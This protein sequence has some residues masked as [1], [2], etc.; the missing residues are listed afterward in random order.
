MAETE[1]NNNGNTKYALFLGCTIPYRLPF[2]EAATRFVFKKLGL[3]LIDLPFG[4]CPDPNGIRSYDEKTWYALAARNLSLAEEQNL[5][6]I[7]LCNGCFETLAYVNK[8]LQDDKSLLGEVNKYLAKIN[9]KYEAKISVIHFHQ[10]LHDVIGYDTLKHFIINPLKELN[11]A[12]HYGCHLLRPKKV[13]NVEEPENP[14]WLWE[15]V[16][17][18]LQANPTHYLDETLCCGAGIR[19]VEQTTSLKIT[20]HKIKNMEMAEANA[21]LV[22]C[23][24]CHLQFDAGQKLILKAEENEYPK[25]NGIPV[26]YQAEL[27][28]IA[29][30]ADPKKLGIQYHMVKPKIEMLKQKTTAV[31]SEKTVIATH[32]HS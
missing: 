21:I 27:L 13:L 10:F 28:A 16:E 22:P 14:E 31:T 5:N 29:M 26:F 19:E 6:I 24:T 3:E 25:I 9:R 11:I 2:L 4:C 23:P 30:G 12:V 15:F 7:T 8:K 17:D 20:A 32:S 18:V 1:E